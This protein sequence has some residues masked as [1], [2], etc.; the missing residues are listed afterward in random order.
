MAPAD[1]APAGPARAVLASLLHLVFPTPCHGCGKALDAARRSALCGRCWAAL[2]RMPPA[3]CHRCG[4]PLPDAA[5][6]RGVEEAL[7][8][9]CRQTADHFRVARAIL[10][11]R[12]GGLAREAILLAKHGGRPRLLRHLAD[13]LAAEAPEHLA[14]T[15]WDA[16]VPVPLHWSR[17]WRRGYNQ[18][19]ILAR[20]LRRR[21]GL[22]VLRV[23]VRTRPTPPQHGDAAERR[24]NV[25]GAFTLPR[26]AAV[27]GRRLLLVDDVFTTGATAN[28]CALVLREAGAADV[29]VLTL[30]RVE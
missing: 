20:G 24:R 9:R 3:G 23:L 26:P 16:V 15:A 18:A 6:L 29:G 19:E 14:L 28:G 11:Y 21:H 22:P 10:L 7:C 17:R 4:W 1:P 27:A 13:L 12:G 2:E 5:G 8:Q 25:R 30:A